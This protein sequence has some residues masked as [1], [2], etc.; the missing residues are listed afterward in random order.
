VTTA[1]SRSLRDRAR[2]WGR[3]VL[4]AAVASSAGLLASCG[5][6]R[7]VPPLLP[8]GAPHDEF[9]VRV[10]QGPQHATLLVAGVSIGGHGPYPF[11]VDSGA[12]VSIVEPGLARSLHLARAPSFP[13]PL[14]GV[15]CTTRP[16]VVRVRRWRVG[17]L[18]LPPARVASLRLNIGPSGDQVEG[19]L[20]SD[21]MSRLSALTVDYG[22]GRAT[23]APVSAET[24]RYGEARLVVVRALG[25]VA[26]FAPVRVNGRG[27]FPFVVDTGASTSTI[28][29]SLAGRL[30]LGVVDRHVK[31]GGVHCPATAS[32]VSVRH[33]EVGT[34]SLP[35]RRL[36]SISFPTPPGHRG[37]THRGLAG[38][39]GSDVLSH[40]GTVT[41]DY[42]HHR[43][44]L[45]RATGGG[46]SGTAKS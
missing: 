34:V 17:R 40:F 31:V 23:L 27:P 32:V 2:R 39:V 10:L 9:A 33:W 37:I 3:A 16:Q 6:P 24:G 7:L 26:A 5:Y 20:G 29:S 15:G 36:I 28:S 44:L 22:T 18:T 41:I 8:R 21:V 1:L 38:L 43:L 35:S 14:S 46:K 4:V 30:H 42:A 25:E 12:A 13:Q 19:L 45:G 11:L